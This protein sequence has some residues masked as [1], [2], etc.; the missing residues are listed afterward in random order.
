MPVTL[1]IRPGDLQ[2]AD[3]GIAARVEFVEDLGDNVIINFEVQGQRLKSRRDRAPALAEGQ[4]VRLSF[5][6]AAA[7]LFDGVTGERLQPSLAGQP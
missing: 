6:P 5:E 4:P 7:H 1:G 2:I 3:E